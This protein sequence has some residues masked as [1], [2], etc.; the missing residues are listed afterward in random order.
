MTFTNPMGLVLLALALPIVLMHIL[1]PRRAEQPVSSTFLWQRM[2]RPV[3]ATSPW[4]RLTPS[5]LL[6]LQLLAVIGLALLVANP[7]RVSEAGLARH[8]VFLIDASGS[9]SATDGAPDR[10]ADAAQRAVDVR[11]ELPEAGVASVIQVGSLPRVLLTTSDDQD[12]FAAAV[13]RVQATTGAADFGRAFA[14]AEGL[15]TPDAAIG[16]VLI[17]DGGLSPEELR[18]VPAGLTYEPIGSMA[19]NRA[20]T[21]LRVEPRDTALH[22]EAV[23]E[24]TGGPQATQTLRIDVD[25]RTE[26]S[27]EITLNRNEQIT[28]AVDVPG[29]DQVEAFL[30]GEDLLGLDDRRWAVTSRRSALQVVVVGDG[31]PFVLA[32]LESLDGVTVSQ[33][34]TMV[35]YEASEVASAAGVDLIVFD[36]VPVPED[37]P[38][39]FWAIAA[40]GGV[41]GVTPTGT[42]DRPIISLVRTDDPLLRNLDLTSVAIAAAQRVETTGV[43]VLVGAEAAPLLVRGRHGGRD[44]LYSTFTPS[45]S[46]L[47]I[48]VA[49]PI[50]SDRIVAELGGSAL[51][52]TDL[53]VGQ[54]LRLTAESTVVTDPGGRS[55]TIELGDPLPVADRPGYWTLASQGQPAQV[56]AVNPDPSE[57][58]LTVAAAIPSEVRTARPGAP[59]PRTEQSLR[60][61]II[62]ALLAVLAAEWLLARRQVGVSDKQWRLAQAMRAVVAAALVAA[63]FNAGFE[64]T[65]DRVATVFVLDASDS[66]GAGG[67]AEALAWTQE[68]LRSQPDDAVAG[69]VLFG[70]EA[71]IE[72]L[73]QQEL[74]LAQPAVQV[75]RTQTDLAS[76]LRLG[77]AIL[78]DDA[79][80]RVVLLSDGRATTGDVADEA[81]RLGASGVV[82]DV[83]V[84]GGQVNADTAVESIDTPGFVRDG[85]AVEI[86]ATLRAAQ[87]TT[88]AVS[89]LRDGELLE[90]STIA[91]AP[92]QNQ[93]VFVDPDPTPG[94]HRYQVEVLT[95][96]DP[97]PENNRAFA[98]VQVG[99]SRGVLIIE[100]T[101][102][103][104]A[105]LAAALEAGGTPVT[106]GDVSSI[107]G[108]ESLVQF[109]A[110]VLVD[111]AAQDLTTSQIEAITGSVRDTGRGLVTIGGLQSYGL[112]GYLGSELETVLPVVSDVLDPQRRQTV[113]EVLAI[114][115]SGSMGACHCAEGFG[116][117]QRD[118]GGVTKTD[119]ARAGA[120]RTIA[121]LSPSDEVGVLAF[122][123]ENRWVIDLQALPDQEVVN[124][125]LGS[126]TPDG[127]TNVSMTLEAAA[128]Q[129]RESDASLKHIILFSD[130][131][132][133][134]GAL[135]QMAAEAAEL[136]ENEGITTSVIATGEGAANDLEPVAIAGGGR[137]YPGRD[138]DRIPEIIVEEAL[139]ASR[140]YIVEGEFLP[141]VTSNDRAVQS[142]SASPPLFGYIAS[143]TKPTAST[144]LRIG[145]DNDPL[146]ASWQVGLGTSTAWTSDA[147]QRWSQ[148]WATWDGYVTFWNDVVR[149]TFASPAGDVETRAQVLGDVLAIE[150]DSADAFVDGTQALARVT[151]PN[152]DSVEVPLDRISANTFAA[153]IP[154]D[155]QGV[156]AVGTSLVTSGGNDA[157]GGTALAARS[158]STEYRPGAP[159][160][161]ILERVASLSGGE[162]EIEPAAAFNA[163]NLSP[164]RSFFSLVPW[165]LLLAAL[166]WPLA[167]AVSRIA[168]RR[169]A[170]FAQE[171]Q[172][173]DSNAA[174]QLRRRSKEP[175]QDD[176]GT[177]VSS[178][179][180]DRGPAQPAVPQGV[181][182]PDEAVTDQ[183]AA[184]PKPKATE[185]LPQPNTVSTSEAESKPEPEGTTSTLDALLA[186]RRRDDADS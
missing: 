155:E 111:V 62:A 2:D 31:D 161:A 64:R 22:V 24:N 8:T 109:D 133:E 157:I 115:T 59:V 42:V 33:V 130:G 145:P 113:A 1:K 78:P 37:P 134:P 140:N 39:P 86:K 49:Y 92:G 122:D 36:R 17:S 127:G 65:P 18:M 13:E 158:Y 15:E 60:P 54:P 96:D 69:V 183:P 136:L 87:E 19:T 34:D 121:S 110:T 98:P 169:G 108:I 168:L 66:M 10:L 167:V 117:P 137:F 147:S 164:G 166:L 129:L 181:P 114:D 7:A 50:L 148:S 103:N 174:L 26:H 97:V 160:A 95:G 99:D 177:A 73:V 58:S 106:V 91:L 85:E 150:I 41:D 14:L 125:G 20:I 82:V 57:S 56:V 118:L 43:D 72:A 142:L 81:A 5:W 186:R 75:D 27:Q 4:Q 79:G 80:R 105:T 152:G 182:K 120:A 138:L 119:I 143:S 132:T 51:P 29:G 141:Q 144:L 12:E 128:E 107:N 172:A 44:F 6:A 70:G 156:Y 83:H 32:M 101:A 135:N 30:E 173:A 94:L 131:F 139:L 46:N 153:E 9:M 162:F 38:A 123:I 11:A 84:I 40:P 45:A 179:Q 68:A 55:Q 175:D 185:P 52:P 126:L 16:F 178:A 146:L 48:Q 23:V 28:V 151:T 154:A 149:D 170:T 47:P 21:D 74:R 176:A 100:G 88:A 116:A 67:R 63:L 163:D 90:A 35:D 171:Q 3:T 77:A 184:I 61:W 93:V 76:A 112:G 102:G 159:D 89:L 124:E 25:G 71:R 104:A 53:V 165:L 180:P